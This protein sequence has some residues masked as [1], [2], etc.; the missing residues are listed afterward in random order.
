MTLNRAKARGFHLR[1]E[2]HSAFGQHP[3]GSNFSKNSTLF[4]GELVSPESARSE[5]G[6]GG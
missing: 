4:V 6:G 3:H 1:L 5:G 2:R